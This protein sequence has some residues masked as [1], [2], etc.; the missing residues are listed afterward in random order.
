MGLEQVG[1]SFYLFCSI[2]SPIFH[3]FLLL[4]LNIFSHLSFAFSLLVRWKQAGVGTS[5]VHFLCFCKCNLVFLAKTNFYFLQ[6]YPV[7]WSS[8]ECICD[9]H[10]HVQCPFKTHK[11]RSSFV[12]FEVGAEWNFGNNLIVMQI[13]KDNKMTTTKH[14][15]TKNSQ[16]CQFQKSLLRR[17][18]KMPPW[19]DWPSWKC[20]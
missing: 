3:I 5:K 15:L 9:R 12:P 1:V 11:K 8:D 20:S 14:F 19:R 13:C 18:Q 2:F 4:C 6:H 10:L 16:Y 17:N 7:I